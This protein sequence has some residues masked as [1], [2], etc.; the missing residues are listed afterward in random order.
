MNAMCSSEGTNAFGASTKVVPKYFS[1]VDPAARWTGADG[2][3]AFFA[4]STNYMM[5]LDN[6]AIVDVEPSVPI[7]TAEAFAARRM[8]GRIMERSDM[9]PEKLVGDAG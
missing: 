1:P 2:G 7:R 9:T 6:A 3:A 8:V 5:D 4:Y